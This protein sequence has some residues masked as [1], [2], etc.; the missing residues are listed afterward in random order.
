MVETFCPRVIQSYL[1]RS[2]EIDIIILFAAF[3]STSVE[4]FRLNNPI[5]CGS[6]VEQI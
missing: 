5:S 6:S 2:L 1:L 4:S 3:L